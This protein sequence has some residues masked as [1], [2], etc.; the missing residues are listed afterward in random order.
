MTM[1]TT[2]EPHRP[3]TPSYWRLWV[4]Y[5]KALSRAS[6]LIG[7]IQGDTLVHG[8]GL[9]REEGF[10]QCL[11]MLAEAEA[12]L[13]KAKAARRALH[14]LTGGAQQQAGTAA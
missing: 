11:A 3:G 7:D 2:A 5:R 12:A 6:Y 9:E 1:T 10:D 4:D 8:K 14:E 13:Q